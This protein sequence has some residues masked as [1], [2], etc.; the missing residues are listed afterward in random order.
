M[1]IGFGHALIQDISLLIEN[2]RPERGMSEKGVIQSV[3][4]A[5]PLFNNSHN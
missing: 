1:I 2:W 3:G 4:G 5:T